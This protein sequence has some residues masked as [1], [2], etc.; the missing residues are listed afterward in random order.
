MPVKEW[1]AM[2]EIYI[3]A[4]FN[5]L[6]TMAM[7]GAAINNDTILISLFMWFVTMGRIIYLAHQRRPND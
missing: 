1:S 7:T 5:L 6:F 2:I 4:F 3:V